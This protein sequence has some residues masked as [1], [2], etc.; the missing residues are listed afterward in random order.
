MSFAISRSP[1]RTWISTEGWLSAAVEK[2]SVFLVGIVVLRSMSLVMTPPRVSTPS[3]SGVTSSSSTSLTSPDRIPAWMA[4][5][6]ATTSSGFTP[7]CGSLPKNSFTSCWIFGM[8]VIPPT[9]TTSSMSLASTPAS[10]RHCW[11][12]PIDFWSRSSTSCSSF[13]RE[14]FRARCFGPEASAVTKGR[15]ISVSIVVESSCFAFSAASRRRCRAILSLPRSMPWSFLNSATIQ[16]MTRWSMLS[17][18]RWVSPL[19]ALTSTT[20][21]PTS[22][23]E[24]SNVP[25]PKS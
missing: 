25:P 3:D 22:R 14:S 10:F 9:S 15:L 13:E 7:L 21:S 5:P 1:W 23:T 6:M 2:T 17:P 18:P 11:T 8:R 19:V 4:A 24:M 20:P 16:S 12:G